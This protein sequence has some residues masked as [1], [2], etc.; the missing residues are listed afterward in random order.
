MKSIT[1]ILSV[2]AIGGAFAGAAF[3]GPG[4]A[5]AAF[6]APVVK[7]DNAVQIALFRSGAGNAA[8]KAPNVKT[9]ALPGVNPKTNVSLHVKVPVDSK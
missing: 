5:H 1:R 2:V 9:V 8:E 6:G 3:A 7:K 4:D